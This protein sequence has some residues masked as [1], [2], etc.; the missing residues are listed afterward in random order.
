MST[1]GL[2]RRRRVHV[3]HD[4][5]AGI[6]LA[7]AARTSPAVI[8]SASEQPA[9]RSGISTVFAGIEELGRLGHEV[10]AGQHDHL[11]VDLHRLAGQREAV[12]DDVGHAWKISGVCSC[13]RG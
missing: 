5:H 2:H 6:A 13:A 9:R 10:H 12:A 3:G 8:E 1:L 4:R 11:G 7:A